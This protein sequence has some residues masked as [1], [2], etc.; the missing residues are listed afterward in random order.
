MGF[1]INEQKPN[2]NAVDDDTDYIE[3][4]QKRRMAAR[5]KRRRRKRFAAAGLFVVALLIVVAA[6]LLFSQRLSNAKN[7][8]G[9]GHMAKLQ[10]CSLTAR[11]AA[12][13]PCLKKT[14]NV[15]SHIQ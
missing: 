14:Q 4:I 7:L 11:A 5:R 6:V 2:I 13:L 8:I 12:S 9:T 10:S 1:R 3:K 15:L